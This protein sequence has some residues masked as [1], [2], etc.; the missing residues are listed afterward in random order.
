LQR[1]RQSV[2]HEAYV[3]TLEGELKANT[4]NPDLIQTLD[5]LLGTVQTDMQTSTSSAPASI[6]RFPDSRWL[7][8]RL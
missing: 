6:N 3:A 8:V 2:R 4:K 1:F 7:Q 5:Q